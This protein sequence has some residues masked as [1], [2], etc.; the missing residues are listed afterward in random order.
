[1]QLESIKKRSV[2]LIQNGARRNYIYGRQLEEAGLLYMMSTDAA[3]SSEHQGLS[4]R[5]IRKFFPKL[6]K[7]I[8]R[9]KIFGVPKTRLR[10]SILPNIAGLLTEWMPEEYR[11][12][13]VDKIS[14]WNNRIYG[15]G[16]TKV[17]VNYHGNGGS[18]LNFASRKG[19]GIITDFVI[20]PKYLEILNAEQLIWPGWDLKPIP[21]NMI[22]FYRLKMSELVR[23]SDR[24]L[25][26]SENV[27]RDLQ[28][29][30]GFDSSRVRI[31]PYGKSGINSKSSQPKIGRVLFIGEAGLR[32]GIPYL[33]Q[34]ATILKQRSP[35]IKVI[36][37]GFVSKNIQ[38]RCET[39]D[40]IFLGVIS[41]DQIEIE[42]SQADIFCL[43]SLAEGSATSIF[44]AIN[45]GLPVVTTR[46]S[47]SVIRDSVE[48]FIVP[49]RNSVALADAIEKIINDRELRS[50]MS[51]AAKEASLNYSEDNCGTQ[52]IDVVEE[53]LS[54]LTTNPIS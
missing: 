29:I 19:V 28:D 8:S 27:S 32:K 34:A 40:L 54:S 42:L 30:P 5:L 46:A 12:Y 43:P 44:E 51:N 45:F 50:V 21:N 14:G 33:A 26:P 31:V 38:S 20:T 39:K 49:E 52:F 17:I 6:E 48:G 7:G 36:V 13:I 18:F 4:E 35:H 41:K 11:F 10:N 22:E 1:M 9:R 24:Y 25:C 23:I 37:A 15:L 16:N 47:G 2:M 53:L 3:F